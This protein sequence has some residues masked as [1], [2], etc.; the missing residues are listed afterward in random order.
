MSPLLTKSYSGGAPSLKAAPPP[1]ELGKEVDPDFPEDVPGHA[2]PYRNLINGKKPEAPRKPRTLEDISSLKSVLNLPTPAEREAQRQADEAKDREERKQAEDEIAY[3]DVHGDRL[4]AE[5]RAR[6]EKA[7][8]ERIADLERQARE[9]R[10][11]R[12]NNE[13]N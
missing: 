11:K 6:R 10:R 2:N 9:Y 7:Q 5:A 12:A 4:R 3:L 8:A 1:I 13:T